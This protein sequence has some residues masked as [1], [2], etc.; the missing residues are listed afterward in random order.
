MAK[1]ANQPLLNPLAMVLCDGISLDVV[2]R[3]YHLNGV[4]GSIAF[5]AFPDRS[6]LSVY[7]TYSGARKQLSG[8]FRV[9]DSDDNLIAQTL[10]VEYADTRAPHGSDVR[11]TF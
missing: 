4:V 7:V 2:S 9:L 3:Q 11:G 10:S 8:H 1:T 6:P 5:D